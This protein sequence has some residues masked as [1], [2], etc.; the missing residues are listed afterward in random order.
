MAKVS[1]LKEMIVELKVDLRAAQLPDC[2]C[3]YRWFGNSEDI[4][5][6]CNEIGCDE[7]KMLYFENYEKKVRK[8]VKKL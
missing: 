4:E 3:P 8:E 1:E 7:C 2:A 5:I 6:D